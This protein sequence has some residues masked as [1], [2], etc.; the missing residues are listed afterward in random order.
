MIQRLRSIVNS[1]STFEGKLFDRFFRTLI[2][3]SVISISI[4]TLP[5]ASAWFPLLYKLELV[6]TFI[7]VLEYFLRILVTEKKIGF[8][9]SFYG[10]IDLGA[11]LPFFL[12]GGSVD[13]RTLRIFRLF[14]LMKYFRYSKS[15]QRLRHIA[16]EVKGEV[17][18]Y[19]VTTLTIIYLSAIGIYYFERDAQPEHFRSVIHSLW[20]AMVTLTTVGYGDVYPITVGGRVFTFVILMLSLGI[21][22]IPSAVLASAL[23]KKEK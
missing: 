6:I 20:W 8:I 10:L 1:T 9:F 21:V 13:L 16:D 12:S 7:F 17:F 19:L 4:E 3:I 14:I 22:S 15:L 11:L 5:E 18:V 23:I 2:F